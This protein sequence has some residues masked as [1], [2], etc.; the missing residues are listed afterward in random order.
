MAKTCL[1]IADRFESTA[2]LLVIEMRR[3]GLPCV[4]WNL[5]HYPLGSVLS[6]RI[7]EG[8]WDTE[9][10]SD[11]RRVSFA[12]VGSIWCRAYAPLGFPEDL[13]A[14]DRKFAA[15]E[16]ERAL[17]GLLSQPD[18]VWIN[19]PH[20][21]ILA[22]SKPAQ[23]AMARRFGLTIAPTLVSNDP[24]E[25]RAFIAQAPG[26]VVYK[27]FSQGLDLPSGEAQFTGL[28]TAAEYAKLD[29]I[30]A[31]PGVFQHYVPKDYELRVTVVGER[32]FAGRINS[33]AHEA[34]SVDW[35]HRPFDMEREP[36]VLPAEIGEAIKGFMRAFGLIYGA[37]DFIVT[38]EGRYVFLEVNPGGQYMWVESTTGMP[39]TEALADALCA[40]C[41]A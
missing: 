1:L 26:P 32:I 36:Y 8:Q 35:R 29:L 13:N 3:R 40:P 20:R 39:I 11:G 4:R 25:V 17:A 7:S 30:R 31:T 12:D 34:S 2:D 37:F 9:I 23:L 22:N 16:A 28:V 24:D 15:I 33:Q 5:D 21:H 38:P 10:I 14:A 6:Y 41:L 19:H 18:I 27:C